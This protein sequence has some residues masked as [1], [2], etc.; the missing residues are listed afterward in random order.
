MSNFTA[1]LLPLQLITTA[2]T[3]HWLQR[4]TA[5]NAN[6]CGIYLTPTIIGRRRQSYII[7]HVKQCQALK[8]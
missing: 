7:N 3:C 1:V 6:T 2:Q 4:D 5:R 8:D